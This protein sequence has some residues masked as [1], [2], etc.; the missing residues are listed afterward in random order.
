[1]TSSGVG[2]TNP[3]TPIE[4]LPELARKLQS[5]YNVDQDTLRQFLFE[6]ALSEGELEDA[7]SQI[8][9]DEDPDDAARMASVADFPD[10]IPFEGFDIDPDQEQLN[11]YRLAAESPKARAFVE[12]NND[13]GDLLPGGSVGAARDAYL[14]AI[15]SGALTPEQRETLRYAGESRFLSDA[16][17]NADSGEALNN[18]L[19][20]YTDR[21]NTDYSA[22]LENFADILEQVDEVIRPVE[23]D[24][25]A[26]NVSLQYADSDTRIRD[27]FASRID[28]ETVQPG[29]PFGG[30]AEDV[31]QRLDA[32]RNTQPQTLAELRAQV[33]E[34]RG[35]RQRV[36]QQRAVEGFPVEGSAVLPQVRDMI[37][38]NPDIS[39]SRIGYL[40]SAAETAARNPNRNSLYQLQ[41]NLN[42]QSPEEL[43]AR[44]TLRTT[45]MSP[46]EMDPLI[47][48][49]GGQTSIPGLELAL[50]ETKE[51]AAQSLVN[52]QAKEQIGRAHV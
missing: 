33:N 38:S 5:T 1:M 13:L 4:R 16:N 32:I 42:Q 3:R 49:A 41:Q 44:A 36:A 11:A 19:Q 18:L 52:E 45:Q 34:I 40:L 25:G 7:L 23:A 26:K 50:S 20:A 6:S 28:R 30:G 12:Q 46:V 24:L 48:T 29:L 14:Q 8:Y 2:L 37:A 15:N 10:Y 21:F 39:P 43:D 35:L 22:N 51:K 9:P 47:S 17:Y 27:P 31:R